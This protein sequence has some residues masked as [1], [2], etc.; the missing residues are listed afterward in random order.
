MTHRVVVAMLSLG[1]LCCVTAK[2]APPSIVPSNTQAS[3]E[4]G[5]VLVRSGSLRLRAKDLRMTKTQI[6]EIVR[7]VEGRVD[8][9]SWQEDNWLNMSL[10]VPEGK[11]DEAM[12]RIGDLGRVVMRSLRSRDVTEDLIDLD[13]R[14]QNLKALRDRLRS[15]LGQASNLEEILGVERELARVQGEIELLEAK[16]KILRDQIAMSKLDVGVSKGR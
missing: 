11:L 4:Q 7:H 3:A 9:W 10:R 1:L 2:K 8:E 12:D 16:L 15:Y 13:V 5:R 14:L 6:D